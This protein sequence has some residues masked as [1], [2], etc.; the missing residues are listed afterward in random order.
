MTNFARAAPDLDPLELI[1]EKRRRLIQSLYIITSVKLANADRKFFRS[2]GKRAIIAPHSF[3][4]TLGHD[5]S[6]KLSP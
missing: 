3:L 5:R 1:V 2:N 4:L 6:F